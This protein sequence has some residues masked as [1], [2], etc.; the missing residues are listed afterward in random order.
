MFLVSLCLSLVLMA[1]ANAAD[2]P[3]AEPDYDAVIDWVLGCWNVGSL[4]AEGLGETITVSF[5]LSRDAKPIVRTI[6]PISEETPLNAPQTALFET[7]RRAIIRC[8]AGGF[9]LPADKYEQWKPIA[10]TFKPEKM[11][12]K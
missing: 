8:G 11:R 6:M 5:D 4:D 2:V 1:G 10:I 9:D 3:S 7:A 12:I